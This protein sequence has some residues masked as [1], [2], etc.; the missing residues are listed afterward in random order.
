MITVFVFVQNFSPKQAKFRS[1]SYAASTESKFLDV[2]GTNRKSFPLCYLQS[3]V[4]T[5][6]KQVCNVNIIHICTS[7]LRTLRN[8]NKLYVH[9]F[10]LSIR[11]E[12]ERY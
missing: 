3:P 9:E 6:L 2:I 12:V 10:G 11:T 7:S 5:D 8:F 4:L 1:T